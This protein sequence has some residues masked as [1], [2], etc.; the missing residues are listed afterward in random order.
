MNNLQVNL[1]NLVN[2]YKVSV[3]EIGEPVETIDGTRYIWSYYHDGQRLDKSSYLPHDFDGRIREGA[4]SMRVIR[5]MTFEGLCQMASLMPS[6]KR[7][8]NDLKGDEE[9]AQ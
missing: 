1:V 7:E 6:L 5:K 2:P 8:L 3:L 4:A 9:E